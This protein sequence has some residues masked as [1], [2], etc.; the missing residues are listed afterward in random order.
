MK[1]GYIDGDEITIKEI[2]YNLKEWFRYILSKKIIIIPFIIIG[3]IFG[4]YYG[5]IKVPIYTSELSFFIEAEESGSSGA[6]AN[7]AGQFG[8]NAGAGGGGVFGGDNLIALMK[9]RSII[10]KTLLTTFKINDKIQ[11]LADYYIDLKKLSKNE[12]DL[13]SVQFLPGSD[14][15]KFSNEQNSLINSMFSSIINDNLTIGKKDLRSSIILVKVS[16][17][18]ELFSLYFPKALINVVSDF[19]IETKTKKS[20]ANLTILQHQTDS[21]K[22][23]IN[24]AASGVASFSDSNPNPNPARQILRVASQNRQLDVEIYQAILTQLV[25]NLENAKV[26]LRKDTPLIQIIDNP[27]L[28]LSKV[29][30]SL[31]FYVIIGSI[32]GGFSIIIF[33]TIIK[34]LKS[35]MV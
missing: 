4:Y 33:F 22:T 15:S 6:Y 20:L 19:Y 12:T 30:A 5:Y 17:P 16:S 13:N 2:I 9:S 31:S 8:V 11:T 32:I 10:Q 25:Q 14:P 24:L 21:V 27:V 34:I 3:G 28:P 7:L 18:D 29:Q 1:T 35:L 23:E 26:A